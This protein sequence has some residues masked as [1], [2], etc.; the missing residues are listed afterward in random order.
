M[1]ISKNVG[2]EGSPSVSNV[3]TAAHNFE[4]TIHSMANS[5]N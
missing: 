4:V 2:K 3:P 1:Q 5:A